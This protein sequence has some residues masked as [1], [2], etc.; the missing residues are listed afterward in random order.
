M[1]STMRS[2]IRDL[3][4][5][6]ATLNSMVDE[7]KVLL[8]QV[9]GRGGEEAEGGRIRMVVERTRLDR[10]AP[11]MCAEWTKMAAKRACT[12]CDASCVRCEHSMGWCL[13]V[14]DPSRCCRD[15]V[16]VSERFEARRGIFVRWTWGTGDT[17][18]QMVE[19]NRSS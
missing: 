5:T 12:G 17:I 6:A 10:R 3:L 2:C 13:F 18:R 11:P 7:K 9:L 19:W 4:S 16:Y 1:P 8:A 15:Q 14:V